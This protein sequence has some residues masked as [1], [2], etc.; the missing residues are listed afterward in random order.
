VAKI[1]KW[2][3]GS[4]G[5][6]LPDQSDRGNPNTKGLSSEGV[7]GIEGYIEEDEVLA[8]IDNR[9]LINLAQNDKILED[10]L[11]SIA[12]E[13]DYGVLKEKDKEFEVEILGKSMALNPDPNHEEKDKYI[14]I[15]PLRIH[16]GQAIID[17]QVIIIGHQ[18][19]IYFIKENKDENGF[20]LNGDNEILFPNFTAYEGKNVIEVSD[21]F[22]NGDYKPVYDS[23]TENWP[24]NFKDFEIV[25]TN[26]R[27]K[28]YFNLYRDWEDI[29]PFPPLTNSKSANINFGYDENYGQYSEGIW[30]DDD[31]ED[32][33]KISEVLIK[34]DI[35][36]NDKY[37]PKDKFKLNS[38]GNYEQHIITDSILFDNIR[39][40]FVDSNDKTR[41][42]QDIYVSPKGYIYFLL[43]SKEDATN[44]IYYIP[45]GSNTAIQ[46]TITLQNNQTLQKLVCVNDTLF[47]LGTRGYLGGINLKSDILAV[48]EYKIRFDILDPDQEEIKEDPQIPESYFPNIET[49]RD[50]AMFQNNIY[51][52]TDKYIVYKQIPVDSNGDLIPFSFTTEDLNFINFAKEVKEQEIH[53][54]GIGSIV[55]PVDHITAM[56][57]ISGT[58]FGGFEY[59]FIGFEKNTKDI[60]NPPFAFIDSRNNNVIEYTPNKY[61]HL[62][63]INDFVLQKNNTLLFVDDHNV[64]SLT[65]MNDV[66]IASD[67]AYTHFTIVNLTKNIDGLDVEKSINKLNSI[68]NF[69]NKTFF[70]GSITNKVL[71]FTI[72]DTENHTIKLIGREDYDTIS[73]ALSLYPAYQSWG[74][75]LD[76]LPDYKI[77]NAH[78]NVG[79][80]VEFTRTEEIY[81]NDNGGYE[82][83]KEYLFIL[84][85]DNEEPLI[86]IF[87]MPANFKDPL[88][89]EGLFDLINK[90]YTGL[91]KRIKFSLGYSK[92]YI[93]GLYSFGK[94]KL[95]KIIRGNIR[96]IFVPENINELDHYDKTFYIIFD[97]NILRAKY[98]Q[99]IKKQDNGNYLIKPSINATINFYDELPGLGGASKNDVYY[100]KD[101]GYYEYWDNSI[102]STDNTIIKPATEYEWRIIDYIH[103]W[104][105]D[106]DYYNLKEYKNRNN[107]PIT[108]TN[109]ATGKYWIDIPVT[110]G[111]KLL[112]GSLRVKSNITNSSGFSE[113]EDYFVDYT[114]N[115]IITSTVENLLLDSSLGYTFNE[116]SGW[117]K[118][119]YTT[120]GGEL[121]I[122]ALT[123]EKYTKAYIQGNANT[124]VLYQIIDTKALTVGNTYTFSIKIKSN[125]AREGYIRLSEHSTKNKDLFSEAQTYSETSYE[126][127]DS[128]N[129]Y[130]TWTTFSVSHT[131]QNIGQKYLRVEILVNDSYF[132]L[133][134]KE[135]QLEKNI[136][137]T[138]YIETK[139]VSRIDPGEEDY[140][141]FIEVKEL[142]EEVDY[143]FDIENRKVIYK[144]DL[145]D[146]SLSYLYFDYQYER[147]FNPYIYS[148]YIPT[149]D[150]IYDERDDYFVY[151]FSGKIWA[152]NF[153]LS[154]LSQDTENPL[155]IEYKYH[156]PRIDRIRLRNLPDTYGNFVYITQGEF[157]KLNPYAPYDDGTERITNVI[158]IKNENLL[159]S[160][161]NRTFLDSIKNN[162]KYSEDLYEMNV[163]DFDYNNN[164]IYDRRIYVDAKDNRIYNISLYE[165]TAGYF[166]YT[167]DF[168]STS[169]ISP[170][171]KI[172][173]SKIVD[174]IKNFQIRQNEEIGAW[175][176]N[177]Q[178]ELR[179]KIDKYPVTSVFV[180]TIKGSDGNTNY[181]SHTPLKTINEA[182]RR[183]QNGADPFIV[184]KNNDLITEDVNVNL[185]NIPELRIIAI[186][187]ARWR[188]NIQNITNLTMQGFQ[189]ENHNFYVNN[190]ISFFYCTFINS[191]LNNYIPVEMTVFN[192][193]I[194]DAK[195]TF[196]YVR[197]TIIPSPFT[198]PN[199]KRLGAID[200][201]NDGVISYEEGVI[202]PSSNNLFRS[203]FEN[204]TGNYKFSH[205]LITNLADDFI[206]YELLDSEQWI[207]EFVINKCT[208]ARNKL[209]FK[210]N[211]VSQKIAFTE[212]IIW[213]C[214]S[215]LDNA[216]RYFNTVSSIELVNNYIDIDP[217]QVNLDRKDKYI[218]LGSGNISGY[219]T[220]IG[221]KSIEPGFLSTI[222]NFE[223]YRLK[224]EAQGYLINSICIDR[225]RD[226]GDI[227]CYDE[228]RER[229]DHMIPKKL[230]SYFAFLNEGISYPIVLNS[231]KITFNLEF[232]P[233]G[234]YSKPAVLF[235][236][237]S[238]PND[239]DF[240]IV[241]YNNNPSD[242]VTDLE[243]DATPNTD[244]TNR[245]YSF[246]IIVGNEKIRYAVIS[247]VNV[248]SDVVY[249]IW[250]KLSFTVNFEKVVNLKSGFDEKDKY[251]NIITLY[252]NNELSK[253]SYLKNDLNYDDHDILLKGDYEASNAWNYNNISRYITIAST[254]DQKYILTGYYS[255][256]RIDNRFI[257]RKELEA[258][259]KKIVPFNDPIKYINQDNF[260]HTFDQNIL[261]ELWTLR[262]KYDVGIKGKRF[263]SNTQKQF[264]YD[265]GELAWALTN[266][267][268]N[269]LSNSNFDK[270]VFVSIDTDSPPQ[271]DAENLFPLSFGG[272]LN[273]KVNNSSI[274]SDSSGI[275]LQ[276]RNTQNGP[277]LFNSY[278]ALYVHIQK[279]LA[280]YPNTKIQIIKLA[281]NK[282]RFTTKDYL[283]SS[284]ELVFDNIGDIEEFG[285]SSD[286]AGNYNIVG[287]LISNITLDQTVFITGSINDNKGKDNDD[288]SKVWT[289]T[290]KEYL[291]NAKVS[292]LGI[293]YKNNTTI[294]EGTNNKYLT[295]LTKTVNDLTKYDNENKK[296][297]TY[298]IYVYRKTSEFNKN[299]VRFTCIENNVSIED[300]FDEINNIY[301]YWWKLNKSFKVISDEKAKVGFVIKNDLDMYLDSAMLNEKDIAYP[302][303]SNSNTIP[304]LIEVDKSIVNQSLG[305]IFLRFKP[306]FNYRTSGKKTILEILGQA[307][308]S[309]NSTDFKEEG[310]PTNGIKVYYEYDDKKDI[311]YIKYR[312]AKIEDDEAKD[313]LAW[314]LS[315]IEKFWNRWH[316]I[317]ISYNFNTQQYTYFFDY[318][319]QSIDTQ[320]VPYKFYT[321][322]FIGKDA[323][324]KYNENGL[325]QFSGFYWGKVSE[326][327]DILVKDILLTNYVISD[328]EIHN[329]INANEFYKES[330]FNS[331]LDTYQDDM[332]N[333]ITKLEGISTDTLNIELDIKALYEKV[334][335]VEDASKSSIPISD[336]GTML[337]EVRDEIYNTGNGILIKLNMLSLTSAQQDADIEEIKQIVVPFINAYQKLTNDLLQEIYDRKSADIEMLRMYKSTVLGEG[338][339]Q[340]G[341]YNKNSDNVVRFTSVTVQD[342]LFELE[343]RVQI[344]E[345]DIVS[346]KAED[347]AIYSTMVVMQRGARE[348][349]NTENWDLTKANAQ[350][351]NITDIRL[352]SNVAYGTGWTRVHA[353]DDGWNISTL[354]SNLNQEVIDRNADDVK[355]TNEE[356]RLDNIKVNKAGIRTNALSKKEVVT[357]LVISP[358]VISKKAVI[359]G[360]A[361]DIENETSREYNIDLIA[362]NNINFTGVNF[363]DNTYSKSLT[364]DINDEITARTNNDAL[365]INIA[366]I[367]IRSGETNPEVISDITITRTSDTIATI[368]SFVS[369]VKVLNHHTHTITIEV[370]DNMKVNSTSTGVKL[371][372]NG[373]IT[374][375]TDADTLIRTDLASVE[376]NNDGAKRVGVNIGALT[377]N[378]VNTALAEI[379]TKLTTL[380]NN[381][382]WKTSV[383]T[384]ADLPA[385]GNENSD[386]RIVK[387]DG[388]GHSAQYIW[389]GTEWIKGADVDWGD[390]SSINF[391]PE[392]IT[393]TQNTVKTALDELYK[394]V[395]VL[396]GI[397][398][399]LVTEN[400]WIEDNGSW[401]IDIEH[402]LRTDNISVVAV[403]SSG[404]QVGVDEYERIDLNILRVH[405][406]IP[407][408]LKFT[409]FGTRNSY[410][411]IIG[412]T[413][414]T[415]NVTNFTKDITHGFGTKNIMIS[416]FN[417][418]THERIGVDCINVLDDN[419]IRITTI[420]NAPRLNVF[421][422]K[423]A[424]NSFVSEIDYWEADAG[425]Y[426]AIIPIIVDYNSVYS[427]F[428][429]T[430]NMTVDIDKVK[431]ENNSLEI[432]RT[433]NDPIRLLVIK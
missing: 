378:N 100:I 275:N 68:V 192:C 134:L 53:Y 84:K 17:G 221:N 143:I 257:D 92:T 349:G 272:V 195:N 175:N 413:S 406:S 337:T 307:K 42:I 153:I 252:H 179:N 376:S 102:V 115:K 133:C 150:V 311:G 67:D 170:L 212:N 90:V 385:T 227:G 34:K 357:T 44:F 269:I 136:I 205:C 7:P 206:N 214:G 1:K 345:D 43:E 207:S 77:V 60:Y 315:I 138:P 392:D 240:I 408:D 327:A 73:S 152:I 91:D 360:W 191:V 296:I 316:T 379:N 20:S 57:T 4:L 254:F 235:D 371:D 85:I 285:F 250:H 297:Y 260:A 31:I 104:K 109:N 16:S 201:N 94:S 190:K 216:I 36:V 412:P 325:P 419:T 226:G 96:K 281:D 50:I 369:D 110:P 313:E 181:D 118:A 177:Y 59:L 180:D 217:D 352:D 29:T 283:A 400:D 107:I 322:L 389:N 106:P 89:I 362:G 122:E 287:N 375:R 401:Y 82:P 373:E 154:I 271:H 383:N 335:I 270:S 242:K 336:M 30:L 346:L 428:D 61:G 147:I 164:D 321:N 258:W 117:E 185:P 331:I 304:G 75:I 5:N 88:K 262:T 218:N 141:D 290:D 265:S 172:E 326:S 126:F 394:R 149:F 55:E 27:D 261:N 187:Y 213:D 273:I 266:G 334:R 120:G 95:S 119:L 414:W 431:I 368:T 421:I 245:P 244:G 356:T 359:N 163:I 167:K 215:I 238:S 370:D 251:Q 41:N 111:Y 131:I 429:P 381:L 10:N 303:I 243:P 382:N 62:R 409:I 65:V 113:S 112:P 342:A 196:L 372:I 293:S 320:I 255:E 314:D 162:L 405:A 35:K 22:Y 24:E 189:F 403:D 387:D 230:R 353:V 423:T 323:I 241:V 219:S 312:F 146:S 228:V 298:T 249:Q 169:G 388:D 246:K 209:L 40:A 71:S 391:S 328:N 200:T 64:Y 231:E 267:T 432:W 286:S 47:I 183:V 344:N 56:K 161:E 279:E 128:Q 301:G 229:L 299:D 288:Y 396:P 264:I 248:T 416:I 45:F 2:S 415:N 397:V 247:P 294:A 426:K 232:K 129:N 197:N 305:L 14:N 310:D 377:A 380:T 12:S 300:N 365:K 348:D 411:K 395:D 39:F 427:F 130:N 224:S 21:K 211:K 329:W 291:L 108:F 28:F 3:T 124:G 390:A 253:E 142:E 123:E 309:S 105:I 363:T 319:K 87:T 333:A 317:A 76:I 186:T 140:I 148:T 289:E 81:E 15:T 386:T 233:S 49:Y 404:A 69:D 165:H 308:E 338:A 430:T 158:G 339:S 160:D 276:F 80:T 98:D 418:E 220:G 97:N 101:F 33:I 66:N 182:I 330:L 11:A 277:I 176:S 184:I 6:E 393:I 46:E 198:Y 54:S 417:L 121:V 194:K 402:R 188:G 208:F 52:A 144:K 155:Y 157:D 139:L 295:L 222:T 174:I 51:I 354:R 425:M 384:P 422:L 99:N 145:T 23:V 282:F 364:I 324:Y 37:L 151:Y 63:T 351:W 350:G 135:A 239:K 410:S 114:N 171:N 256:L 48:V 318:F 399:S 156:Y 9:P 58:E 83:N 74:N 199:M 132:A 302:F 367:R 340:I 8:Y 225:A 280:N 433:N 284:I 424:L 166:P 341:I 72:N 306:L 343:A 259:N 19:I 79:T 398:T 355:H 178:V 268:I 103:H 202:H 78:G 127:D 116:L 278:D 193:E 407:V 25:I 173:Y 137:A 18:K 70:G 263:N 361:T 274:D 168:M 38:D 86:I 159:V 234:S 292:S 332:Y 420:D 374:A 210:T 358:D 204:I 26:E 237:R 347:Q 223:D 125:K 93:D 32:N 236:S 13:V 203:S 366:D